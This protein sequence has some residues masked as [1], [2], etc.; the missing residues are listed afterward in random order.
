MLQNIKSKP[1]YNCISEIKLPLR[2]A[3][4][5]QRLRLSSRQSQKQQEA[6]EAK[7]VHEKEGTVQTMTQYNAR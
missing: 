1:K 3:F 4:E 6:K 7:R 2:L 5:H